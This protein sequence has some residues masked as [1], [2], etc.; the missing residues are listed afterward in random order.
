MARLLSPAAAVVIGNLARL[1]GDWHMRVA[2]TDRIAAKFFCVLDRTRFD[3][4]RAAK[5]DLALFLRGAGER[6]RRIEL[7]QH[8][9]D[10]VADGRQN[11]MVVD[12]LVKPMAVMKQNPA[13]TAFK[14][15][16]IANLD[17]E[18][19]RDDLGRTIVIAIDPDNLDVV[20][21]F[22]KERQDLPVVFLQATEVDRIE[23]V[24]VQNEFLGAS[25]AFVEIFEKLL[26]CLGLAIIAAQVQVG[27]DQGIEQG[28][29]PFSAE[30]Y[31]A[32]AN[33][34]C[35]K[36]EDGMRL[37]LAFTELALLTYTHNRFQPHGWG[38]DMSA[39]L[40]GALL[41]AGLVGAFLAGYVLRNP[42]S[43]LS[44]G[45]EHIQ[46]ST[47]P[48]APVPATT[49]P[50]IVESPIQLVSSSTEEFT[51]KIDFE[52][53]TPSIP[54]A[55]TEP[56]PND[57]AFQII[58]KQLGIKTTIL[59]E[60][61][62]LSAVLEDAK[63]SEVPPPGMNPMPLMGPTPRLSEVTPPPPV[64][65]FPD[66]P[67]PPVIDIPEILKQAKLLV[68]E[69]D[70]SL[71]FEITRMGFSKIVAVELWTTRDEGK[72]WQKTDRKEGCETPFRTKLWSEGDYGFKL[73]FESETG[74]K[75]PEP[76]PGQDADFGAILDAT[77]PKVTLHGLSKSGLEPRT[78]NI[79]WTSSD[80]RP[81]HSF[82]RI[83]YSL[84]GINWTEIP[85][86]L[87]RT[88]KTGFDFNWTMPD[89]IPPR[90]Q[91]R[92]TT[93]DKSGNYGMAQTSSGMI[94]DL[95]EPAGKIT[96]I[97]EENV[98]PEVG[99]RPR[100]VEG[101]TR[102]PG[103]ALLDLITDE[104]QWAATTV[105]LPRIAVLVSNATGLAPEAR[106]DRELNM[107]LIQELQ[108]KLT[109]RKVQIGEI[110]LVDTFKQFP[111][112]RTEHPYDFG[113][114]LAA[115]FVI[116]VEIQELSI[117]KEG[118]GRKVLKGMG[119][120][121]ANCYDLSNPLKEPFFKLEYSPEYPRNCEEALNPTDAKKQISAFR[122]AFIDS[123]TDYLVEKIKREADFTKTN[124]GVR[125]ENTKPEVGPMPQEVE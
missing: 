85:D 82:I 64:M 93:R 112:W 114:T 92:I 96:G 98:K 16:L 62:P 97:R 54:D 89:D 21:K 91:L 121:S 108:V 8:A 49:T 106:I 6:V 109:S 19:M 63:K 80:E 90:L 104:Y 61:A 18:Q 71:D 46:Q 86:V 79:E 5:E 83:E 59:E 105:K 65:N 45:S 20:R 57:L 37:G 118:S 44:A 43:F 124:V 58:K 74:M 75:T 95:M 99:P 30:G 24:A 28:G 32:N 38:I 7:L 60:P 66:L 11:R 31:V 26:K 103:D 14:N 33:A 123:I 56:D 116:D 48:V 72:T 17:A 100:E 110:K 81:D 23:H 125:R 42:P 22:A 122:F 47:K 34:E 50:K 70:I 2:T 117:F 119:T 35:T 15:D 84:E 115:N 55:K 51:P 88:V 39:F 94:V 27:N 67:P 73:V 12:E 78:V 68:K 76:K 77:P 113:K 69:R 111:N 40:R 10:E 41:G 120:I 4:G 52:K 36:C 3:L 53:L 13:T 107:R 87:P 25:A 1:V 9:I 101:S 29:I 102:V